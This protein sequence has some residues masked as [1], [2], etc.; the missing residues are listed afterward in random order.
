M[1][2]SIAS[3]CLLL[4]LVFGLSVLGQA[5]QRNAPRIENKKHR[6]TNRPPKITSFKSSSGIITIPC[7]SWESPI[8]VG[9]TPSASHEVDLQTEAYDPEGDTL[10]YKYSVTDGRITGAGSSVRWD[11]YKLVPDS[12]TVKVIVSDQHGGSASATI[13][14]K[15]VPC[16]ICDPSCP[17]ISISCPEDAN[18]G[19]PLTFSANV[20]GVDPNENLTYNWTVS[21]GT[22]VSGQ[23]T[24]TIVVDTRGVEA[25]QI[26]ATIEIGGF[27][28]E[29]DRERSCEVRIQKKPPAGEQ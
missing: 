27:P 21:V 20:S 17:T 14:L 23:G 24:P 8:G 7:P 26:K 13:S 15:I 5:Q 1:K 10:Q 22:I 3:A 29:C 2:C 12:Y 4:T 11:Y 9:C 18:E 28:P 19:Q 16:P 6:P 25:K